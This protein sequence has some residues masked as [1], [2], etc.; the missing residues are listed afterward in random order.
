MQKIIALVEDDDIIRENYAELLADA[1]FVINAYANRQ[2]ALKGITDSPPDLALL[3]ITLGTERDAGYQL[4]AD[5]RRMSETLPIVFLTSHDGEI[6]KIL[7]MRLGADDYIT[8]DSS[9]D[10]IVVRLEAL[11]RR[12][13]SF[14]SQTSDANR[15]AVSQMHPGSSLRLD[16]ERCEAYWEN[17]LIVLTLTHFWMLECLYQEPGKVRRITELMNAASIVVEPNT[18]VAHVKA[19]RSAFRSVDSEFDAIRTER[20]KGYRWLEGRCV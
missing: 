4:C 18:V 8:K 2:D 5:L 13:S 17:Q 3:D 20:G 11:F 1:G 12:I 10:F 9:M 19:I 16:R 14:S 6:D 7:G 15:E